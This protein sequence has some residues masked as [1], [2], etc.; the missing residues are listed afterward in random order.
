MR[1]E[2]RKNVRARMGELHFFVFYYISTRDSMT[3]IWEAMEKL[4]TLVDD[5]D[6]DVRSF[7][8]LFGLLP[9][10]AGFRPIFHKLNTC[11][12]L[13]RL[14][15]GTANQTGCKSLVLSTISESSFTFLD[16]SALFPRHCFTTFNVLPDI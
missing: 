2:I 4:N 10:V 7:V 3:G 13:Q 15:G 9:T 14:C 6:P 12:K 5:S 1:V 11:S 8:K 16:P